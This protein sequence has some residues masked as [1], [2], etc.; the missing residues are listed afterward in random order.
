M[1]VNEMLT[2]RGDAE[3]LVYDLL[4]NVVERQEKKNLIVNGG[5]TMAAR[6][7]GGDVAYANDAI[8]KIAFGTS[9]TAAAGSQTALLAQQFEKAATVDY[10]AFNQVRFSAT[11]EAAEGG[12]HTY[13]EIGLRTATNNYLFSRLVISPITKSSAYRIQVNWTISLQ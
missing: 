1:Q 11:M 9:N 10:P 4:G 7:L 8:S 3:I 6:R 2:M 13:Q 12:S 5:K